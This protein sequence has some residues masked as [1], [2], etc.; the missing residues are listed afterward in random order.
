[1]AELYNILTKNTKKWSR[2]IDFFL[3]LH[4][5]SCFQELSIKVLL[6]NNVY[7]YTFYV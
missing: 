3:K 6:V 4:E 5:F 2:K 7:V 1:M